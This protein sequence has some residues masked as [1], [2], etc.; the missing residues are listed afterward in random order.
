MDKSFL[1]THMRSH[2]GE[3]PFKCKICPESFMFKQE[4]VNHQN[5]LHS[6]KRQYV[7][8][9]CKSSFSMKNSLNA[10]IK[11]HQGKQFPCPFPNC[12]KSFVEKGNMKNHFKTHVS[13]LL[14][15]LYKKDFE[16]YLDKLNTTETIIPK[17]NQS[18]EDTFLSHQS[19][20]KSIELTYTKA[21]IDE[22][23]KNNN[24]Q[25]VKL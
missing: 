12:G 19:Q 13:C 6:D 22:I 5:S 8:K 24:F 7:C 14:I 21:P 20:V 23:S 2:T 16:L 11:I 9:K 1:A 3:K 15:N 17:N 18:M 4:Q 10:H 25:N